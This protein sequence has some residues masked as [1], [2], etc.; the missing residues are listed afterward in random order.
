MFTGCWPY[1]D[2]WQ[3]KWNK[4]QNKKKPRSGSVLLWRHFPGMVWVHFSL[5][6]SFLPDMQHPYSAQQ[7]TFNPPHGHYFCQA[8]HDIYKYPCWIWL[9]LLPRYH[10][11]WASTFEWV[12]KIKC[13]RPT[14]NQT[15][16]LISWLMPLAST[17]TEIF[18]SSVCLPN[19]FTP[20]KSPLAI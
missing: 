4:K 19:F 7:I 5:F 10:E 13:Y 8:R 12:Q 17:G 18:I 9:P 20:F 6:N 1:T 11:S 14:I 16:T 3:I 2:Q 15:V